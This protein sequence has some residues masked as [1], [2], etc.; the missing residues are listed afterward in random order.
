MK[1]IKIIIDE[2]VIEVKIRA[3]DIDFRTL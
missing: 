3:E 2:K 1:T